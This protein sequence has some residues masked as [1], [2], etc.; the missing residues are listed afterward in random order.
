MANRMGSGFAKGEEGRRVGRQAAEKA[1]AGMGGGEVKLALVFASPTY[2]LKEVLRGI[3]EVIGPAPLMGCSSAGEFSD[4]GVTTGAVA[5]AAL[6]S[7]T[8]EVRLGV[9]RNLKQD[10]RASVSQVVAGFVGN[11]EAA[12]RRGYRGR[13]LFLMTDGLAG[14][15]EELIEELVTQTAMQYQLF[16]GAAGDDARFKET[17]V[18]YQD[19]VLTN[20]FVCAEVLSERPLAIGISHGWQSA[21]RP[22]RVTG[23]EGQVLREL[24][25]RPAW[26]LY[27][28]FAN[29]KGEPIDENQA[30]AFLMDHL[31]GMSYAPKGYK[32]RVPLWKNPDGS[33]V[34]AAE[35]PTGCLVHIMQAENASIIQSG[36]RA[37]QLAQE[38]LGKVPIAG[39][40]VFEC[41]ATRLKL[42]AQ[43]PQEVDSIKRALGPVPLIG[44]NSYGQLARIKGEFIGLMDATALICLIPE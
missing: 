7:E 44:C 36:A 35:I 16:G 40:L 6:A 3:R 9:G 24:N 13:T 25:G 4:A 42:G 38:R 20:A 18:F 39:A 8:L 31:L 32:L 1:L 28:E 26:E 22:L 21:S 37:V 43:F 5:V 17:Y 19:Q 10:L 23:V 27:Q 11:S 15:A 14:R 41:V 33:L 30:S 2:D 34:C 29:Q 12:L